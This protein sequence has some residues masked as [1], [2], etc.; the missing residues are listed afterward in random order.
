MMI[1]LTICLLVFSILQYVELRN[2]RKTVM[3]Q[4]TTPKE[5]PK[6][7]GSFVVK[8]WEERIKEALYE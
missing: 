8:R 4:K 7:R 6:G 2:F 3:E 1:T 5:P